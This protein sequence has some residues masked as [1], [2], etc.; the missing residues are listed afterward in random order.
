MTGKIRIDKFLWC[1]RLFKSRKLSNEACSKSKVKVNKKSIKASY[2][3]KVDDQ[4]TI[5]KRLITVSIIVLKVIDRRI[6]AKLLV[7]YIK[8]QTPSS[9]KIKIK[10]YRE[11]PYSHREKGKGRPTK[12]ERRDLMKGLDDYSKS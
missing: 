2:I 9:E 4:I 7:E 8:D 11:L 3:I 1:V 10:L 12:K 6:S 5:K